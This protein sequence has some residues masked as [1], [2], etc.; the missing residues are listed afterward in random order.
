MTNTFD[1]IPEELRRLPNWVVWRLEERADE[2]GQV[3]KTK[4]PYNARTGKRAKNNNPATWASYAQALRALENG[5]NGKRYDG[6][7]FCL[8][9]RL[10]GVDLDGVRDP[11]TG[12]IELW[13]EEIIDEL[14]SYTEVSPSG[15]GIHVIVIGQLPPKGR[16]N[17]IG[18]RPHHGVALYD[19]PRYLAM[20]GNTINGAAIAERAEELK[21]IHARLFS[22]EPKA[23]AKPKAKSGAFT[24]DDDLIERAKKAKNGD[25]FARLWGG[26]WSAYPSQSEADLALC[27][28]LAFW[29]DC[30]AERID[31]LFRRSGLM[32]EKWWDREDYG[33][34]T[35]AKAIARTTETY[36]PKSARSRP[37]VSGEEIAWPK[38]KAIPGLPPVEKLNPAIIPEA[39][40]ELCVDVAERMQTPL[41]FV[42]AAQV[43]AMS[44]ALGRRV[45]AQPKALDTSF[46]VVPNLWGALIGISGSRKSPVLDGVTEP[47]RRHEDQWRSD[48]ESELEQYGEDREQFEKELAEWKK[49]DRADPRPEKPEQPT[50][51]RLLVNDSTYEDVHLAMAENGAGI[52]FVP[53][54]VTRLVGNARPPRPGRGTG[55]LLDRLGGQEPIRRG[56]DQPRSAAREARLY[57]L[58]GVHN[59]GEAEELS[60]EPGGPERGPQRRLDAA[61]ANYGMA[62]P[63]R[64]I[65]LCR[66]PPEGDA[67]RQREADLRPRLEARPGEADAIPV[68]AEEGAAAVHRM[69]HRA[70]ESEGPASQHPRRAAQ[71]FEQV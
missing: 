69:G 67:D 45:L 49:G 40:R 21:R 2:K 47:L 53:R 26:D 62:R 10:V 32:R 52:F 57:R 71:S 55:L 30:D 17:N 24:P 60:G 25:K 14:A 68:R 20:T 35:I 3:D 61:D 7:G 41:D 9:E 64:R 8:S 5:H 18:D 27:S 19:P 65:P 1:R 23:K 46:L 66:P 4:V 36:E 12:E 54:R 6:L 59:A 37:E 13:A 42:F 56:P 22:P 70:A 48:Y 11:N 16:E 31:R 43:V 38:P 15:T 34:R 44:A 51:R 63:D 28:M 50:L 33:N 39:F 29:T 58:V